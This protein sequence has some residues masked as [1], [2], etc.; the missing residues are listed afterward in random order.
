VHSLV[1][2]GGEVFDGLGNP[3]QRHDVAVSEGKI[4]A[5]GT[6]VGPA[7]NTID[8]SG[9]IVSPGFIDVHTHLDAQ[10]FWDGHAA[11]SCFH[12]VTTV[13]L[14]NCGFGVAPYAMGTE[15]YLLQTLEVVEEIPFAATKSAVPFTWRTFG[16]YLDSLERLPLG[17]NVAAYVPHTPLRYAIMGDRSRFEIA[18]KGDL[19]KLVL[20]LEKAMEAGAVGLSTSRGTNHTDAFGGPVPSRLANDE[21]LSSLV[22]ATSGRAWQI[23]LQA[24]LGDDADA[25]IE[26]IERY[27]AFSEASNVHLSWDPLLSDRGSDTW[28][29]LLDH[30]RRL[31]DK[32]IR[33]WPQ[34]S[35]LPFTSAVSLAGPCATA[36]TREWSTVIGPDF[37]SLSI[38][39]RCDRLMNNE[40]RL[41]LGK[42]A[43]RTDVLVPPVFDW[44]VGYSPSHPGF[45]GKTIAELVGGECGDSLRFLLDLVVNDNLQTLIQVPGA[46]RDEDAVAALVAD[47][48]TM[49]GVGDAGAHVQSISNY[50]YPTYVLSHFVRDRGALSLAE[51]IRNLTAVP[52]EFLGLTERGVIA[53]GNAADLCVFDLESLALKSPEIRRD[54]PS[55]AAR[56]YQGANGY[57]AILVNGEITITADEFADTSPGRVLRS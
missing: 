7:E 36:A 55:E 44:I 9:C 53:P 56:L 37:W 16:E 35:A 11:P 54:F 25:M 29:R 3:S 12:G 57:R 4:V 30:N 45:G 43:L 18:D 31:V 51:A 27:V 10:L 48:Y 26:E 5:V 47:E 8:A 38:N 52:A 20:A 13:V 32:G 17:V 2:R 33:L 15:D 49:I 23:N 34:V 24:K 28:R 19:G 41:E 1:I 22:S 21:E 39:E 40:I 42:I 6:N 14:G 50:T 46:N